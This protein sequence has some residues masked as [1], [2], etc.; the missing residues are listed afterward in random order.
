MRGSFAFPER[1]SLNQVT[2]KLVLTTG[3][4]SL[5]SEGRTRGA[6]HVNCQ[7]SEAEAPLDWPSAAIAATAAIASSLFIL[8]FL[9]F[10]MWG[11][12]VIITPPPFVFA[13]LSHR[14]EEPTRLPRRL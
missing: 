14:Y 13:G 7:Y 12:A 9:W 5:V 10:G 3:S 4:L 8:L 2:L 1:S 11:K 6:P